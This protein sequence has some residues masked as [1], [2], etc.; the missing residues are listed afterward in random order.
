MDST[1]E[2]DEDIAFINAINVKKPRKFAE[3]VDYFEVLEEIGFLRRF[4]L[5]KSSFSIVL[6]RIQH[7]ISPT[8]KR[9]VLA[10]HNTSF[11]F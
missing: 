9:Y 5:S 6:G 8:T 7:E 1:S 10:P 2:S 4:R 3:R 11:S